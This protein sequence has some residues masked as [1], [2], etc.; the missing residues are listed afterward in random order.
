M[1]NDEIRTQGAIVGLASMFH[2]LI[3]DIQKTDPAR[4]R[5]I[6]DAAETEAEYQSEGDNLIAKEAIMFIRWKIIS[7]KE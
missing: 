3:S 5:A 7:L 4:A 2:A 1:T 6:L